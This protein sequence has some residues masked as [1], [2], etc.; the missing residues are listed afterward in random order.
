[1]HKATWRSCEAAREFEFEHTAK[2]QKRQDMFGKMRC[3][4]SLVR[5]VD[6]MIGKTKGGSCV[7]S[8]R[9]HIH[10]ATAMGHLQAV[11]GGKQVSVKTHA[12]RVRK[13]QSKGKQKP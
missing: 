7:L 6:S 13:L 12:S 8:G 2:L 5:F 10:G 11:R 3:R 9:F 1:M 4:L